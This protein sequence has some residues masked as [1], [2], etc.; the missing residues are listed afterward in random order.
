[1]STD[2]FDS[3]EN[4]QHDDR[5]W[6]IRDKAMTEAFDLLRGLFDGLVL[7]GTFQHEDGKTATATRLDGNWHCQN[8]VVEHFLRKRKANAHFEAGEQFDRGES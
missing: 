1:M 4:P 7:I 2:T 8:G 6:Q 3:A 5:E